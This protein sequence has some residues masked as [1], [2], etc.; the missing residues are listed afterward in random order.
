MTAAMIAS[1]AVVSDIEVKI[2]AMEGAVFA[3]KK[4][5]YKTITGFDSPFPEYN[6]KMSKARDEGKLQP[7]YD[8]INDLKDLGELTFTVCALVTDLLELE[9]EDFADVVDDITGVA[10]YAAD[11]AEADIFLTV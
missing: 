8:L 9:L 3:L 6:E 5:V 1:G 11:A 10:S 2:F 4:D 7:W